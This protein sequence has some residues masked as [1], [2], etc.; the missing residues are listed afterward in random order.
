MAQRQLAHPQAAG[1]LPI[2]RRLRDPGYSITAAIVTKAD[3]LKEA[4]TSMP[5][6]PT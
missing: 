3:R 5:W 6:A 4:L 1:Q 2:V